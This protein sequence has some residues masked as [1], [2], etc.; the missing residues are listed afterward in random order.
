V[1]L[2]EHAPARTPGDVVVVEAPPLSLL[3]WSNPVVRRIAWTSLGLLV[4]GALATTVAA[5]VSRLPDFQWRVRPLWLA[6]AAAAFVALQLTHA[7]LW[8][9]VVM[10]LGYDMDS[11]RSRAIWCTSALAKY[12]PGSVLLPMV[13]VAMTKPEGVSKRESLASFVYEM[14]F[15]LTGSVIVGAYAVVQTPSLAGGPWRFLVLAIPVAALVCLHPR[16]FRPLANIAL[17]RLGRQSLPTALPVSTLL[18]FVALYALTWV[19]AGVGMYA[20]I[21]GLHPVAPDDFLIVLAAPAV[22]YIAAAIGF[23]LPG[24]LGAR[25]AGLAA[26][27]SVAVPVAVAVALAVALRLLQIAIE[28]LTAVITPLMAR[29]RPR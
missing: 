27:L 26:V 4:A 7:G 29:S 23:M 14:A 6:A 21:E 17:A 11:R 28:L 8:R 24:G 22:G 10:R 25:E 18:A 2:K 13:R 20:L 1:P 16:V 12:T 5:T 15:V 9:R 3:R 19:L